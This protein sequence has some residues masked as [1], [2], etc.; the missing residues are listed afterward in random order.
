MIHIHQRGFIIFQFISIYFFFPGLNENTIDEN[1]SDALKRLYSS[2][3][4]N[5]TNNI[6]FVKRIKELESQIN[7]NVN[8]C[9]DFFQFAC[10]GYENVDPLIEAID[11]AVENNA[12]RLIRTLQNVRHIHDDKLIKNIKS[13][14]HMCLSEFENDKHNLAS[15]KKYL[16]QLDGWPVLQDDWD[17]ENFDWTKTIIKIGDKTYWNNGF[18][19]L[20]VTTKHASHQNIIPDWQISIHSPDNLKIT[21]TF[22][23]YNNDSHDKNN[24]FKYMIK[25]A[26]YLGANETLAEK[27]LASVIQLEHELIN[28]LKSNKKINRGPRVEN[29]IRSNNLEIETIQSINLSTLN[30]NYPFFPWNEYLYY[31]LPINVTLNDINDNLVVKSPHYLNKIN[32]LIKSKSRKVLAN[33]VIWKKIDAYASYLD[34]TTR[35][36]HDNFYNI[37]RRMPEKECL[38]IITSK[39][40]LLTTAIYARDHFDKNNG[41]TVNE[42]GN[43]I[44]NESLEVLKNSGW[45]DNK[46]REKVI[47]KL[48]SM[49]FVIGHPQELYDTL[50][51]EE[52]YKD[53]EF[54]NDSYIENILSIDSFNE[55]Y[56]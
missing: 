7:E 54:F 44:R 21:S 35:N 12:N 50:K 38:D 53:L 11:N 48:M 3:D 43:I 49:S 25:M 51:L 10:G 31:W 42:I 55:K 27:E 23:L 2:R 39:L 26:V 32:E 15:F 14:Y 56:S 34:K 9:V 13:L 47:E 41:K 29:S 40:L 4:S 28:I 24:Y 1:F 20:E 19:S 6:N 5:Y 46:D 52:F 30:N 17:G 33:Y 45:M 8:P 16:K 37:T 36:Y 18:L 22:L